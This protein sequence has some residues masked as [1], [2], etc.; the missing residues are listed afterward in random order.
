M[1]TTTNM[2]PVPDINALG[3]TVAEAQSPYTSSA[4]T[5]PRDVY[6]DASPECAG[7]KILNLF[8]TLFGAII[9]DPSFTAPQGQTIFNTQRT[10]MRNC[11][12]I[13][14]AWD[15]GQGPHLKVFD[16]GIH[17]QKPGAK[18]FFDYGTIGLYPQF[19]GH[20]TD[21]PAGQMPC[22]WFL[23]GYSRSNNRHEIWLWDNDGKWQLLYFSPIQSGPPAVG[24]EGYSQYEIWFPQGAQ[25]PRLYKPMATRY[26]KGEVSPGQYTDLT[27]RNAK[28][29]V[30][31]FFLGYKTLFPE[32]DMANWGYISR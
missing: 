2:P 12:E 27:D 17:D 11:L 22:I 20:V 3:A 5:H 14:L 19:T 8:S 30:D 23:N 15:P 16:W 1:T 32:T 13:L 6:T 7:T 9:Y 10:P 26:L 21:T 28:H 31:G 4:T 18:C 25:A 24:S 29:W